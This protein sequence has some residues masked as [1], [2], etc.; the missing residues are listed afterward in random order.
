MARMRISSENIYHD[1]Y[2]SYFTWEM[3]TQQITIIVQLFFLTKKNANQ[4]KNENNLNVNCIMWMYQVC[5]SPDQDVGT[6]D[7]ANTR[8]GLI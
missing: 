1:N 5:V 8:L 3:K 4:F 6:E 2:L 7:I